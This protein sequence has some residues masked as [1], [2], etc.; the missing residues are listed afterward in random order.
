MVEELEVL[1]DIPRNI[2]IRKLDTI[3]QII[4]LILNKRHK[5]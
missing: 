1:R 5:D 3:N 4:I 2:F